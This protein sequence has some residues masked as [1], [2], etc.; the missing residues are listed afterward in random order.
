MAGVWSRTTVPKFSLPRPA[1]RALI[2]LW[3][4][5]FVSTL[6]LTPTG[7]AMGQSSGAPSPG[8]S[9]LLRLRTGAYDPLRTAAISA[10]NRT[11]APDSSGL[12]LVQFQG[13]IRA[14]WRHALEATG[15]AV[16]D[17]TPDFAYLVQAS[18][19]TAARFDALPGH[20]WHGPFMPTVRLSSLDGA[21]GS[22]AAAASRT[23]TRAPVLL[24]VMTLPD[25]DVRAVAKRMPGTGVQ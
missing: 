14:E 6:T 15:A 13:P 25:E 10:A 19:A 17:Y 24:D 2:P 22:L 9:T 8:A 3:L 20:R 23:S 21:H 16:I 7:K 5:L 4:A 12:Y 11:G 18:G 1:S